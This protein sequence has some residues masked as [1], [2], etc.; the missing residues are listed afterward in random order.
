MTLKAVGREEVHK[1]GVAKIDHGYITGIVEKPTRDQA[2]S[3]LVNFSPFIIPHEMF[4]HLE[5]TSPDPKSG[6][7]YPWESLQY[8]MDRNQV[9]SCVVDAPLWDTGNVEAR[10]QANIEWEAIEQCFAS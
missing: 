9:V 8:F 7:V 5:K 1:Y 3:N 4:D 2:P 10:R 6:E